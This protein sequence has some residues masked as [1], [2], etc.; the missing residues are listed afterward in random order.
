MYVDDGQ[1][2]LHGTPVKLGAN[3]LIKN[4]TNTNPVVIETY[5]NLQL[6]NGAPVQVT[7]V[8]SPSSLNGSR[9]VTVIDLYH[10]SIPVDGTALTPYSGDGYLVTAHT[11]GLGFLVGTDLPWTFGLSGPDT[12]SLYSVANNAV[13]LISDG[14]YLRLGASGVKVSTVDGALVGGDLGVVGAIHPSNSSI[15]VYA[16]GGFSSPNSHVAGVAGSL[17]LW[18][19]GNPAQIVWLKTVDDVAEDATQ[20]WAALIGL[21][22]Y[23]GTTNDQQSLR[24]SGGGPGWSKVPLTDQKA[25]TTG[26]TGSRRIV[27]QHET[28]DRLKAAAALTAS[29][30]MVSDS[31]GEPATGKVDVGDANHI[32]MTGGFGSTGY[33]ILSTGTAL[34]SVDPATA[35]TALTSYLESIFDS[36]YAAKSVEASVSD[37]E[38]RISSLESTIDDKAD[39]GTYT[40]SG[41]GGGSVTIYPTPERKT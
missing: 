29:R 10:F 16:G 5:A 13:M 34:Q 37:H 19:N 41:G 4:I 3:A 31:N 11:T 9:V 33:F 36:R 27:L 2:T 35:A 38:S 26:F 25:V 15:G 30:P 39:H 32:S 1:P 6:V 24:I 28:Q 7:S 23:D 17:I 14:T 12:I 20:G 21:P 22:A 18:N 8:T 40:V